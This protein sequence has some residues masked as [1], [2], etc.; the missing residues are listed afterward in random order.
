MH[1]DLA[2]QIP[3]YILFGLGGFHFGSALSARKEPN[4]LCSF[5]AGVLLFQS[6]FIFLPEAHLR[7]V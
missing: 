7:A 2:W 5:A 4:N 1:L 6:I 3:V